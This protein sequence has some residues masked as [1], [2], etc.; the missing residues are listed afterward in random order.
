MSAGVILVCGKICSGKSTY[1]EKIRLQTG[2]VVLSCDELALT[3]FG[4]DLGDR[5]DETLAR[6]QKYFYGKAVEVIEVGTSVILEWGFWR[7]AD[8]S[9]AR[10]FFESRGIPCE[11]HY[12]DVSAEQWE[13]NIAKRN[14]EVAQ[15]EAMGYFVDEG[16][17]EKLMGLFEAPE[18]SEIDVRVTVG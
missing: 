13:K 6:V 7:K 14:G 4:D 3:V 16:L 2:A 5:H 12:V 18:V 8:R 15:G 17:R 11:L 1:T 9:Y 10:S